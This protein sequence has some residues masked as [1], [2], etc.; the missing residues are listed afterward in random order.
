[1]QITATLSRNPEIGG[2]NMNGRTI[3]TLL[4][5]IPLLLALA[6]SGGPAMAAP[7]DSTAAQSPT[8]GAASPA[9][10]DST[11][12]SS[13]SGVA[14]DAV[15]SV[16]SE[17]SPAAFVNGPD[18]PTAAWN[19]S[20]RYVGATFKPRD[21]DVNYNTGGSGGCVYVTSGNTNTVWNVP[22]TLPEGVQVQTLR[23][24][25]YDTNAATMNGWFSKYD[26]YGALVQEWAVSS[27]NGGNRYSD[28]A[29]SPAETIDY[30]LYSYVINWRP[31]A[32]A[33]NLQLCGFRLFYYQPVVAYLPM[34]RR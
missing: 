21:N 17:T 24:Y 16:V 6:H 29:I 12:S 34:I 4:V 33:T 15:P 27:V 1:M 7:S 14:P 28:V 2:K 20:L 5:A 22:I 23:M 10:D 25:T 11:P 31:N 32:A 8:V 30:D 13:E 19:R 18:A 26:L 9:F 3:L